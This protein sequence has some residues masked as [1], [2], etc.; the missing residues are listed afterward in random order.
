MGELRATAALEAYIKRHA[1]EVEALEAARRAEDEA[2]ERIFKKE[3]ARMQAQLEDT[4]GRATKAEAK[5]AALAD[6]RADLRRKVHALQRSIGR[7][8]ERL[9]EIED[10]RVSSSGASS[11]TITFTE[12]EV[13]EMEGVMGDLTAQ[14]AELSKLRKGDEAEYDRNRQAVAGFRGKY[15]ELAEQTRA[16][17]LLQAKVQTLQ[18]ELDQR[19]PLVPRVCRATHGVTNFDIKRDR[20]QRG[21]PYPPTSRT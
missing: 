9:R 18:A 16:N 20:S 14:L 4:E 17:I 7:G 8:E 5:V 15:R 2:Q 10:S 6:S 3:M 19:A 13:E 11:S 1:V 21:A 12:D